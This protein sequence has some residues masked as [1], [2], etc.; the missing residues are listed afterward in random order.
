MGK[1][2]SS[3]ELERVRG[4]HS[5]NTSGKGIDRLLYAWKSMALCPS[6]SG[7]LAVATLSELRLTLTRLVAT[8]DEEPSALALVLLDCPGLAGLE[9]PTL[10]SCSDTAL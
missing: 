6:M 4:D 5:T 8:G 3:S 10:D 2:G 1:T 7:D 9:L